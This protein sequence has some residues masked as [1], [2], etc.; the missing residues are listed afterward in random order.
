ML[1]QYPVFRLVQVVID[2]RLAQ[3][4]GFAVLVGEVV[5]IEQLT[6]FGIVNVQLTAN[7]LVVHL[8][9][10]GVERLVGK[11]GNAKDKAFGLVVHLTGRLVAELAT[12]KTAVAVTLVLG[13]LFA[14]T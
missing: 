9:H 5:R 3:N 1:N 10:V 4:T 8:R 11:H 2:G 12:D 6:R 7:K 14:E 13:D